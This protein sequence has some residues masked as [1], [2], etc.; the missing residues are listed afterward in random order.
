MVFSDDESSQESEETKTEFIA[1]P[2]SP[3]QKSD[4]NLNKTIIDNPQL[5]QDSIPECNRSHESDGVKN[6]LDEMLLN[7]VNI[8]LRQI[9]K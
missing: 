8:P 2:T 3:D 6:T 9:S 5:L 4:L 7:E 1:F